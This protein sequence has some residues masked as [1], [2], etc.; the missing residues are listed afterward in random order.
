MLAT[1]SDESPNAQARKLTASPSPVALLTRAGAFANIGLLLMY[2]E[3]GAPVSIKLPLFE[4]T[5]C[6]MMAACARVETH[7]S[8]LLELLGR[9]EVR[10][11]LYRPQVGTAY[12]RVHTMGATG[13]HLHVDCALRQIFPEGQTA[14]ATHKK[15]EVIDFIEAFAGL[16]VDLGVTGVFVL[17][18]DD[19][20]DG[21][22]IRPL[23][24]EREADDV[25]IRL[26]QG[27]LSLDG[28]PVKS[29]GWLWDPEGKDIAID[30]AAQR[31]ATIDSDYLLEAF[32]LIER[33]FRIFV[34]RRGPGEN[35]PRERPR[36]APAP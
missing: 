29:I 13:R 15:A 2:W 34:L 4:N 12:V 16:S 6:Q 10:C 26:T 3:P 18:L 28:T 31:S 22:L 35:R 11:A 23:L 21:G 14:K 7:D 27:A 25:T 32:D 30:I 9:K 19:L 36:V 33:L 1:A 20:P 24:L 5:C 17:R 8:A